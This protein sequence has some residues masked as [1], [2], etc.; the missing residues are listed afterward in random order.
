VSLGD[1]T[2]FGE[3]V[4]IATCK[5]KHQRGITRVGEKNFAEKVVII[6]IIIVI[7]VTNPFDL[8]KVNFQ[9]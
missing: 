5:R 9:I 6:I 8:S 1:A 4:V 2:A 7:D 3:I